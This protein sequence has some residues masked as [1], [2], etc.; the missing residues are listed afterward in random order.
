[1]IMRCSVLQPLCL[2]ILVFQLFSGTVAS[3]QKDYKTQ[4][5]ENYQFN[6]PRV[7]HAYSVYNQRLSKEFQ[8]KNLHYPP[9]EIFIRA[10]KAP[11]EFEVWVKEPGMDTFTLFKEYKICALS[12][13]LGP[14]RYEGDEQVPEGYYFIS[15]FN[16]K[17]VYHLSLLLSYPNYSDLILGNKRSP[18]GDIYIHG[19]CVTIGCLPMTD[20]G[21]Q[22][23]Y[24]LCLAAR[25]NGQVNI[26][27]HVFPVRFNKEGLDYLGREYAHDAQRQRFW[28]NLKAGY[29][30]FEQNKTI[31]PVMYNPDGKYLY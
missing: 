1:M 5:F 15:D 28:I 4:N 10:F 3:A 27:V 6:F 9:R 26:P 29:D 24:T 16:P 20:Q 8:E 14:K 30:Y 23:I 13:R 19:A 11:N 18:G 17:S 22:E 2:C 31:L 12:G 25:L 7:A 21:I